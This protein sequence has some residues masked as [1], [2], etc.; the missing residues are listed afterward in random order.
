MARTYGNRRS[1]LDELPE[2]GQHTLEARRQPL[3]PSDKIVTIPCAALRGRLFLSSENGRFP[4]S[5]VQGSLTFPAN[6]MLLRDEP[7]P[8]GLHCTS[9]HDLVTVNRK[10][11]FLS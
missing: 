2:F 7:G 8:A 5:R 9:A 3:D 10:L 4:V 11:L 1:L 6:F